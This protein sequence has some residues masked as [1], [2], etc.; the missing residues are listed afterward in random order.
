MKSSTAL[1]IT[2][3]NERAS[4]KAEAETVE[5]DNNDNLDNFSNLYKDIA[6][7]TPG[8]DN[9][10][11][12][13]LN[14][15]N[16]E[17]FKYFSIK[18]F[19]QNFGE[20]NDVDFKALNM[21]IRG[22]S[23]NYDNL[24]AYLSTLNIRFDAIIL[25]ECHLMQDILRLD[26]HNK[27]PI[28]NYK[29]YYTKSTRKYGG[30]MV[31]IA[32]QHD[33]TYINELSTSDEICDSLYLDIN[34]NKQQVIIRAYYRHCLP[35]P[36]YKKQ[37]IQTFDEHLKAK[38]YR[39]CNKR[40]IAGDFNICLM[41]SN[42]DNISSEF[43]NTI[44][45]NRLECHVYKPTRITHFKNSLQIKSASLIDQIVSNLYEY[46]CKSGNLYYS[47]SDH[48]PSFLIVKNMTKRHRHKNKKCMIR[49]MK[50]IN[51]ADLDND[52]DKIN[53]YELVQQENN[54]DKCFEIDI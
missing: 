18:D 2:Q 47:D 1:G 54:I 8:C 49:K 14:N 21:N 20:T 42:S 11:F 52:F 19:N 25:T 53:W 36:I 35:N 41:K 50:S 38:K 3:E 34:V 9:Y 40:I 33:A 15:L 27:Y 39:N 23:P 44:I 22:I 29:L 48:F 37:F 28:K 45:E 12:P 10:D 13:R 46:H 16:I 32:E 6:C 43:L 30:L 24:N 31:Y 17:D 26:M 7:E 51:Q 4:C 5:H